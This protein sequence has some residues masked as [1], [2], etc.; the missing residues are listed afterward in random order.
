MLKVDDYVLRAGVKDGDIVHVVNGY[1]LQAGSRMAAVC[2]RSTTACSGLG[3]KT[4][5]STPPS[6]TMTPEH[7]DN[8]QWNYWERARED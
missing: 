6:S 7:K 3:L 4:R 2:L 8:D 1:E 5:V